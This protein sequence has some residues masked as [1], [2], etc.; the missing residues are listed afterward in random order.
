MM[1]VLEASSGW[2]RAGK[3]NLE[4]QMRPGSVGDGSQA[5]PIFSLQQQAP[6]LFGVY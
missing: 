5:L 1:Q 4:L 6:K 2:V 3:E